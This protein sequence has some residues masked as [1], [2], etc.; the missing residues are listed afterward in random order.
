LFTSKYI[1]LV[2]G[3]PITLAIFAKLNCDKLTITNVKISIIL[4]TDFL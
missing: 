2:I 1:S 4:I 3:F